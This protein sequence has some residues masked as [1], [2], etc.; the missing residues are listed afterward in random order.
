VIS[1]RPAGALAQRGGADH[2]K[3]RIFLSGLSQ[4][5]TNGAARGMARDGTSTTIT[6]LDDATRP[7]AP[8]I[9]GITEAQR[10]HGKRLALIHDSRK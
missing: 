10:R 5:R 6:L 8:R 9:E 1:L 7:T 4:N 3:R 2:I